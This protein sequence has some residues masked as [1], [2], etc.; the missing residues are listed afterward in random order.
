MR[1]PV[2]PGW[3]EEQTPT[4]FLYYKLNLKQITNSRIRGVCWQ[5]YLV[6]SYV[7]ENPNNVTACNRCNNACLFEV[8]TVH[9][10]I[11]AHRKSYTGAG[12]EAEYDYQLF[13]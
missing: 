10:R 3:A 12:A 2:D 11:D 9:G 4:P 7:K 8:N 5:L 13:C 6:T 1:R